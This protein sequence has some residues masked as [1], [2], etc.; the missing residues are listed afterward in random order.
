LIR[1]KELL[2]ECTHHNKE[3]LY[4]ITEDCLFHLRKNH[5]FVFI[6]LNSSICTCSTS[7]IYAHLLEWIV[8]Q[9]RYASIQ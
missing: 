4:C 6:T 2:N 9:A 7:H 5:T 1:D 8:S 3:L